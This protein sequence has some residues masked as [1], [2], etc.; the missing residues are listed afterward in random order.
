MDVL[1]RPQGSYSEIFVWISLLEVCQ[2]WGVKNGGTWRTLRAPDSRLGGQGHP[3]CHRWSFLTLRKILWKFRVDIFIKS[4]S[5]IGGQEGGY[6]ED[7][8][9]SWLDTWRTGSSLMSWMI[10]FYAKGISWKFC[11]DIFIRSVSRRGGQQRVNLEDAEGSWRETWRTGSFL[12]S[13]MTMVDPKD[14]IL[15][16]LC[17]SLYFWQRYKGAT[18][19]GKK[20]TEDRQTDIQRDRHSSILI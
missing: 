4:M 2:E 11:V 5:G 3:W 1:G 8:E 19:H 9:C 18:K 14:H 10:L 7:F 20:V 17:H 6:L 15:K 13:W 12:T 16:V